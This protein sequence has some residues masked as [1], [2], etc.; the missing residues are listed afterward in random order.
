MS[1][2]TD[3]AGTSSVLDGLNSKA[4]ELTGGIGI[5]GGRHW[6]CVG[7]RG[8]VD[9]RNIQRHRGRG[10]DIGKYDDPISLLQ[11]SIDECPLGLGGDDGFAACARQKY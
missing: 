3:L 1:D 9:C 6:L 7:G 10:V 4:K 5:F 11:R 8:I 2:S